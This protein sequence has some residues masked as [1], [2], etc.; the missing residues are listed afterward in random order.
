MVTG[1]EGYSKVG[2]G[3]SQLRESCLLGSVETTLQAL[4]L[5]DNGVKA[6]THV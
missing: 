6:R 1:M 2:M 5:L 3:Y 4:L